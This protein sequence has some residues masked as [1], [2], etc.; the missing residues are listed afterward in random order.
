MC[1]RFTLRAPASILAT[2]FDLTE[3]EVAGDPPLAPRYNIAPTQ[4]IA[5]VRMNP[6]T[7]RR[8]WAHAHWGLIPSWSKDPAIGARMINARSET[9]AEK[10]SF[11]AAFKRRRCLVPADGFYEWKKV[12]AKKQ[13]YHI[14]VQDGASAIDETGA[15]PFAIAGLWEYWEGADGSALESCTLLTTEANALMREL[16]NRMPVVIEPEDYEFWLGSGNEDDKFHISE[17]QH[18]LRPFEPEKM[19][20]RPVST[21]VNNARNEGPDCLRY[22]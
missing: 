1:G 19:A 17:L 16:H 6:H 11:R 15:T 20:F 22:M 21:Y 14:T 5:I 7:H 12:G 2:L 3:P 8:E 4:P 13:P 18:L 10:P 9:V